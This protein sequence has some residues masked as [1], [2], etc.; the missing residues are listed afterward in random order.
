MN[1]KWQDMASGLTLAITLMIATSAPVAAHGFGERYDLPFPL[2]YYL[3]GAGMAVALSFVIM[4]LA[5]RHWEP[6]DEYPAI[7]ISRGFVD[8]IMSGPAITWSVRLVGIFAFVLVLIAGFYGTSVSSANISVVIIW[9][10]FWV[11]LAYSSALIGNIWVLLNPWD[12]IFRIFERVAGLFNPGQAIALNRPYPAWLSYWPAFALFLVFAWIESAF[13]GSSTPKNLATFVVIYSFVTFA[14]M[15]VFG[16]RVWLRQAEAFTA[17]FSLLARFSPT[18]VAVTDR[19]VC[20][21]CSSDC[22]I[23]PDVCV[24]CYDCYEIAPRDTRSLYLRPYATG[25][26]AVERI[27]TSQMAMVLTV[28]ATVS[29]D[30]FTATSAWAGFFD[31]LLPVFDSFGSN[32][33]TAI[34]SVGLAAM[35]GV[36]VSVYIVLIQFVIIASGEEQSSE[37]VARKFVLSLVPIALAYH[38]AHFFSFLLIQ[39]QLVVPLLSDPLGRDWDLFGTANYVI[40]LT[41]VN[42]RATWLISV[43][44]IVIGHIFA[45]YLAHMTALKTFDG[46]RA[47]LRSQYPMLILMVGYTMVGLWILA[48]PIVNTE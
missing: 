39:G 46:A 37:R 2:P 6:D 26:R 16:R 11:G 15:L 18:E 31:R 40:D 42:A 23:H 13:T 10:V 3:G 32:T 29:F 41:I 21:A 25:L 34:N 35:I 1:I 27:S 45:V 19:S 8:S 20:E 38:L 22:E 24:D 9:V 12:S 28:L 14:G 4:G 33:G 48:Q 30:G 7:D 47:A 17:F 43:V 5:A 36:F 44:A